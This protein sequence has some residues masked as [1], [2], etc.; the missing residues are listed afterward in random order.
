ML[1]YSLYQLNFKTNVKKDLVGIEAMTDM[2][3][4]L[5]DGSAMLY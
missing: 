3:L 4:Y 5:N 1:K 2:P